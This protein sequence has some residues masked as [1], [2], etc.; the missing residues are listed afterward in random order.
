MVAYI[1]FL[2]LITA[3]LFGVFNKSF[4]K[5]FVKIFSITFMLIAS[6]LSVYTFLSIC[7]S[8]KVIDIF[9]YEWIKIN[10]I[11]IN[12]SI[13]VDRLTSIMFCIVTIISSIVHIYSISYM[14]ED[15]NINK[16]LSYLSLFT[17]FML[18][19]VCSDNL[20]QLFIGWEG[21]GL[22]SYLLIGYWYEKR[23]ANDA[24]IKAFIVNRVGDFAF[25]IALLLLFFY[26]KSLDFREIFS[27]ID[28]LKIICID[29][30]GIKFEVINLICLL[31]FIG[32]MGKSA[33]LGLHVWLP[34][35][36]EGPTPVSALI[37][38]ATMVTAGIF[39]IVRMSLLF[40]QAIYIRDFIIIIGS[41]TSV[42]MAAIAVTNNDIKK[43][44][45]YSTCSQL[46]YMFIACGSSNYNL[47]IFHLT[48]H[49]FFKALL[50]LCAG[51]IIHMTH[52][53][54]LDKLGGLF[55]KM[56]I[57]FIMFILGSLA[58][59]GIYPFAGYYSKD[60][61]IESLISNNNSIYQFGYISSLI[62]VFLTALYSSKLIVKVFFGKY[63]PSGIKEAPAIMLMPMLVLAF[64]SVLAGIYGVYILDIG[65]DFFSNSMV[66]LNRLNL[67]DGFI[68]ELYP[69]IIGVSGLT[70]GYVI[71]NTDFFN[72][73][74]TTNIFYKIFV[75]K[76]YFDEIYTFIFVGS[77]RFFAILSNDIDNN[78][79]DNQGP[80]RSRKIIKSLSLILSKLQNGYLYFYYTI[81]MLGVVFGLS[82]I[83]IKG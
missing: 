45:A 24:A 76:L 15:K 61:I 55:S 12:L 30:F 21:V 51:N 71:Y 38:A 9:L 73:A 82:W 68:Q 80:R 25:I 11:K 35:A 54:S 77:T 3:S 43:I 64:G 41:L 36:M 8:D 53:Q 13:Y 75:N 7:E 33:Q 26:T 31:L 23:S 28:D 74:L 70:L 22:C 50:F 78:L 27:S 57:T 66:V 48:T 34:D 20:L 32:S 44:I 17:F 79:I 65:G 1:L 83:I 29:F 39:L 4:P 52:E 10:S 56:K 58:L 72:T 47:A 37:H 18:L 16:F 5:I 59:V 19:L 40:E 69:L 63:T 81:A 6:F 67:H 62:G 60:L 46:G 49:A 42:I 2:P 14:E